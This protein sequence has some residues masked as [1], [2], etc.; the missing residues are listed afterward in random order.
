MKIILK[1]FLIFFM[2]KILVVDDEVDITRE[3]QILLEK[4]G[5]E[6]VVANSGRE[7]LEKVKKEKPDVILL[8]VMMPDM[9][10]WDVCKKIKED[11]ST[12]DI[13]VIMLT[14]LFGEEEKKKSFEVKADAHIEKPIIIDRIIGVI[15]WV[16]KYKKMLE[17][18]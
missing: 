12:K 2:V 18:I 3:L 8:D 7:A 6:V 10:G 4:R 9:S 13:P 16:L 5:Y 11:A 15:N 17:K 14:I 1:F